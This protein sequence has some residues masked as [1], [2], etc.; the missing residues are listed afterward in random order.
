MIDTVREETLLLEKYSDSSSSFKNSSPRHI[1]S[2]IQP[3]SVPVW[4]PLGSAPLSSSRLCH[5]RPL[6]EKPHREGRSRLPPCSAQ[7][8]LPLVPALQHGPQPSRSQGLGALALVGTGGRVVALLVGQQGHLG[9]QPRVAGISDT[10]WPHS[11]IDERNLHELLQCQPHHP[12][13]P[14]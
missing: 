11:D 1:P 8:P 6:T 14:P 10:F 7:P 5:M 2:P 4:G 12:A 3:E 9:L 13:A